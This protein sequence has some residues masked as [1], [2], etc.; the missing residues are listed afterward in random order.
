MR[1]SELPKIPPYVVYNS[2]YVIDIKVF[3]NHSTNSYNL[4]VMKT[5]ELPQLKSDFDWGFYTP[6]MKVMLIIP[7]EY[8]YE[9]HDMQNK[10][11]LTLIQIKCK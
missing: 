6:R 11:R 9:L 4:G 5:S 3:K 10:I 7:I 2:K 1:T 8:I